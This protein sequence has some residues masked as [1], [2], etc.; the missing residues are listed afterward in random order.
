MVEEEK[1]SKVIWILRLSNSSIVPRKVHGSR[2]ACVCACV[3]VCLS[4]SYLIL[5]EWAYHAHS[6]AERSLKKQRLGLKV[7]GMAIKLT[8]GELSGAF[9]VCLF[10]CFSAF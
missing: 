7:V 2:H 4:Q 6:L 10:V 8:A 9:F 1:K 3:L 5:Q